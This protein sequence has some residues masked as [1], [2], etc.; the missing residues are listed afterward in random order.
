MHLVVPLRFELLKVLVL[1]QVSLAI[2]ELLDLHWINLF[3]KHFTRIEKSF[4]TVIFFAMRC[5]SFWLCFL[6]VY[7]IKICL[8]LCQIKLDQVFNGMTIVMS[9]HIRLV[10]Y[11]CVW[12]QHT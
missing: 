11:L 5:Q 2:A 8:V 1:F 12:G 10:N 3:L 7:F 6:L 4:H 9:S